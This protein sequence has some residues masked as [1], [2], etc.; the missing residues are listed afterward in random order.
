MKAFGAYLSRYLASF[1]GIVLLLV[2]ANLIAFG[3]TFYG[4]ITKD[5]G[6]ISPQTMLMETAEAV[7]LDGF[8][9]EAAEK[10]KDNHIWAI[11]LDANGNRVWDIDAPE[12][13]QSRFTIQDVAQFS[14][15]YLADY[16][17]FVWNTNDG[18]LV[19]GYPKDSYMKITSNYLSLRAIKT[20]PVFV[21]GMFALDFILLFAAYY[22]S[23]RK[24]IRK[25]EPIIASIEALSTGKSVSL[26]VDG[27]LSEVAGSVNRAA[28]LLSR[29]NT[30]RANWIS[31]VSHDIRTPLS[32]IMGYAG[33]IAQESTASIRTREEAE[34]ISR[35]SV[36]IKELIQDLNL[37]SQLEYEAQP[38]RKTSVRLSA[39]VRSYLAELLNAGVSDAYTIELDFAPNAEAV[40]VDCD[41]RLISR[42]VNNLV[43][44]SIRH[45]PSGCAIVLRLI[46]AATSVS[47]C[48]ADNGVGLSEEKQRELQEV[49][50][51]MES[52]DERLDL[53]HGL[54]LLLVRQIVLAHNGTM[55]IESVP[56]KG[57][58]ITMDFPIETF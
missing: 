55:T 39:L 32:V 22:F 52:I 1:T 8:T 47:L 31:G 41:A 51:Y 9:E 33:R 53:R 14:K 58:Q 38:I 10:L 12:H 21:S 18:L 17:V 43:Q 44:N 35:Q 23:K 6:S 27:E 7:T 29:Q 11:Y 46:C 30:A 5:H 50:H 13:I 37:V 57:C 20:M 26:S 24:I 49:P 15:G 3:W 28:N 16:P 48:V 45:N 25:T 56:Q 4:V 54:G 40:F 34:T 36:Q 2:L 42:A 19:L